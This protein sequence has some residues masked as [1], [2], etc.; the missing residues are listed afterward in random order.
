MCLWCSFLLN[1]VILLSFLGAIR[2]DLCTRI[3]TALYRL[4]LSESFRMVDWDAR[5][6]VFLPLLRLLQEILQQE[7]GVCEC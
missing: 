4:Q 6:F 5:S 7:E 1:S 3:P 2:V